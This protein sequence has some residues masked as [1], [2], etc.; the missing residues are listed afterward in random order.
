MS[1]MQAPPP[2]RLDGYFFEDYRL[3]QRFQHATPRTITAGEV[4]LNI[5]L[6]GARQ[7]LHCAETVAQAL[8]YARC[9]IDDLL[10]F[11]IAFGKTVPDISHNAVANLGYADCRF[12]LPVFAGDTIRCESEITGLKENSNGKTGVVYVRSNALNQR[13]ENVLTW[14]R[15]VMVSRRNSAT[16]AADRRVPEFP[17][18]VKPEAL[19]VPPFL[20]PRGLTSRDTGGI[21]FWDDYQTME[22]ISHPAGMT[23]EEAD[24]MQ[25]TRLYQNTA[26]VH[27]DLHHMQNSRFG[28][29]LVYGGHVISICRALSYDGLENAITIAAINSGEHM[30]P[31]FAGDT[32]YASSLIMQKW[33]LSESLGAL[34]IKLVGFKNI[35]PRSPEFATADPDLQV[36]ALDYTV[37]MP[38]R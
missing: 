20:D 22:M 8:G 33:P 14:A 15:W 18:W 2:R 4:A 29:R 26:R 23:V 12:L 27:F 25:A 1:A 19:S 10:L 30:N 38:R 24:H 17:A 16:P 35:D 21:R 37:L 13:N 28:R 7:P 36:L 32:L 9:P 11:N 31:T 5:A 34:Q 6:S 3:G